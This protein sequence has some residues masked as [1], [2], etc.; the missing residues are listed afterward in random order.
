MKVYLYTYAYES[1]KHEGYKSLAMFDK[2]SE[3]C[4]NAVWTHRHSAKSEN[5][6]DILVYLEKTFEGRLRSICVVTEMAP[7]EDYAHPYLNYLVCHADVISFDLGQLIKDNLVEAVYCKDLRQTALSDA[8]YENIYKVE[9]LDDIGSESC[10]WHLCEK[11]EYK[12]LSPWATIKHYMLVLK[13]GYIPPEYI[14]L[15]VDNSK[16]R[17][18]QH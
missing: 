2:N 6:D 3:H 8:S 11:A 12:G 7:V 16:K 17:E 5:I 10:D 1:I 4:K 13:K 14:T 18:I 15:E 9:N